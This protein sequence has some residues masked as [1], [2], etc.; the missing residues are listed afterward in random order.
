MLAAF[1]ESRQVLM[2]LHRPHVTAWTAVGA[3]RLAKKHHHDPRTLALI[4]AEE[5][6]QP[7]LLLL[8]LP[9]QPQ[10]T[11]PRS[12]VEPSLRYRTV[13]LCLTSDRCATAVHHCANPQRATPG[14]I[15]SRT[16]RKANPR[17]CSGSIS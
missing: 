17:P 11:T 16:P 14:L 1:I 8:L 5:K 3:S 6:T 2:H 7:L 12:M 10:Q 9:W 15:C 4:G 13:N